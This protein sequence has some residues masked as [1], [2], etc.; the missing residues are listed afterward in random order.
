[1]KDLFKDF[2]ISKFKKKKPPGNKSLGTFK[3]IK[4]LK[5]I[6]SDRKFVE[7]KDDV[8][9]A[10]KSVAE[11]NNIEYPSKLVKTLIN[12]SDKPIMDLK[13]FYK[14]PRPKIVAEELGVELD[15][16]ELKTMKTPSYPSGHS[17]QGFLIGKVLADKYPEASKDF[18]K[19]AKDI[20]YSRNVA[21]A[22]YKSDSKFGEQLGTSMYEH[23]KD[24]I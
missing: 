2:N 24:K 4:E 14:R 18:M 12:E 19:E 7:D 9:T 21:K 5:K 20:S 3:E 16:I 6:K 11:K 15:D 22:H 13:N 23:I 1:M 17:A 8:F 10:F